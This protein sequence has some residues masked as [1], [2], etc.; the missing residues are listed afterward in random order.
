[1][2]AE[3]DEEK[4]STDDEPTTTSE[5]SNNEGSFVKSKRLKSL[6]ALRGFDMLWIVGG[7]TLAGAMAKFTD[8]EWVKWFSGQLH[9]PGW[10]GFTLYDLI[11]PLFLFLAGVAM[12][13]SLGRQ[14]ELGKSKWQLLRKVAVRAALL[15]FLGAVYNGLFAW[16]PLADTRLCSVL[17]YIGLAYFFA[18]LI[19][20]FSNTRHQI[21]WSLGILF[22]Y[23]AALM[24]I[25]VPGHGAGVL[26]PEDCI[27]GFIDRSLLP[28]KF[29]IAGQLYDSQGLFVTIPAIVTALLGALTGQF[30]RH[31]KL[32]PF[33]IGGI[34]I[35]AGIVC[36]GLAKLWGTQLFISKEL[37]NPTFVLHCA[38]W[39]LMLLGI[40]YLIIDALG[41]W[42][43]SFFLIVIGMNSITIYLAVRM[44]NFQHTSNFLFGGL[45]SKFGS[46]SL[47][48]VL[49]SIAYILTWWLVLLFMYRKKIFLR[50]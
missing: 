11:F 34:L 22:G 42:R 32:N 36:Y 9:H 31:T 13:Y 6:D 23:W 41:F 27:T 20:L 10:S 4:P 40:F 26:T 44:V 43:W 25:P 17:G 28:W 16:K 38:G 50:V 46:P 1:M 30:I 33:A 15:V 47:Q 49:A 21:I 18:A 3:T 35:A 5:Q 2:T 37:W 7:H 48:P 24:W 29:N 8:W 39:S 14:V 45:I 12:P 19:Y